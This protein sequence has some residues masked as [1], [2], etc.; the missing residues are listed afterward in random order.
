MQVQLTKWDNSLAVR[1]PGEY[2]HR[3]HIKAGDT[4]ELEVTPAGELR[5]K[6]L[7]VKH[8]DKK[9][10]LKRVEAVQISMPAGESVIAAMRQ[11]ERY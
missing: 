6:P 3:A 4:L 8:F 2:A 9:A 11:P 7:L 1:I 5:L 10:F